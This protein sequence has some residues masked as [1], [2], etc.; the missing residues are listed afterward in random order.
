MSDRPVFLLTTTASDSHTWNLVYLQLLLHE[1]AISTVSIGPCAAVD[2]VLAAITKIK[3]SAVVVSTVNGHGAV[4]VRELLASAQ[5]TIGASMPPVVVGGKLT[6]RGMD[7][8]E[9]EEEMMRAG[10]SAVFLG[11]HA[12]PRFIRWL[13]TFKQHCVSGANRSDT[14]ASTITARS[15]AANN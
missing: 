2:D 1:N 6:T 14:P 7:G 9:M 11:E 5:Q 3:P 4:Q 13:A 8:V 15:T 12:V 10:A